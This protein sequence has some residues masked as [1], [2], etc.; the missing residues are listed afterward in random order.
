MTKTYCAFPFQHQYVHMSGSVRLCCATMENVT[1]KKDNRV[2][3][4]NDSLQKIWNNDYMKEARLKM[5]NGEVL[6]ACTKCIDQEARGYKSMR[7]ENNEKQNI[8]NVNTDGSMDTM[9]N[10]MELHF[11]NVC[12]LKCK[13]CGQ[14]YSNQIGKEILQIGEKD[15]DFLKWVYK[16]SGNVNNW[17]NNLSVEYTWFQNEKT[18]NKL[19]DYVSKHITKLTIIGGEPTVIPEFYE[20]LDYCYKNN[21]LK[22]KDITIVT[23]LTNTN[24]KMTQWLPK[25]KAWTIWASIDGI[26]DIT[27]YIR[28]PSNFKKVVENLNFYKKLLLE[29]N[30]GKIVFSPAIQLLN[31]HQLDDML[32]WFIDFADNCWGKQF[33][34]S[35]M[36]QVWYPRICNYDTAPELYRFSV[37]DK[38]AMSSEQFKKYPSITN[39]YEKQIKNLR[40]NFIEESMEKH[41][42][43]AF[44]RYNDTQDKHRKGKTW[45]ELLPELEQALTINTN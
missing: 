32:K 17:T 41:L 25:M 43:K 28:Y 38:L 24:P 42:Q 3:M 45:R 34:I 15:K 4:N 21:T 31:I 9:P 37:A 20:L 14:D 22:D 6:K 16:Q 19:I 27:E 13:M 39:F 18:K 30:N 2:H 10:S 5:K 35:W 26:E 33:D 36:S 40:N 11:G 23:N 1:D 44:I 29:S 7:N 12:N 8:N